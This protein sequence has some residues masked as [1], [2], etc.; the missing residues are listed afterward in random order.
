MIL[1]PGR[2]TFPAT[3]VSTLADSRAALERRRPVATMNA[4][5]FSAL[6]E[7]YCTA[8]VLSRSTRF[9]TVIIRG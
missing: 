1:S 2:W 5:S 8:S 7:K 6:A 4:V 3:D 9:F